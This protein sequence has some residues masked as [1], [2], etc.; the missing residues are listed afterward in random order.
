M[1]NYFFLLF[2][3]I[4]SCCCDNEFGTTIERIQKH[5]DIDPLGALIE[6]D[7][8]EKVADFSSEYERK[9]VQ[10]LRV[11]LNDKAYYTATSDVEIKKLLR[12]FRTHGSSKE[13]QEAFYYAGSVYRD[14]MDIPRSLEYFLHS[15]EIAKNG[16][17]DT[18]MLRNSYSQ[19]HNLY[20]RVQ[21]YGNALLAAEKECD[22]SSRLGIL[23]DVSRMHLVNA[24]FRRNNEDI[25]CK[26]MEEILQEEITAEENR[27]FDVL[28]DLLYSYS[29]IGDKEKAG[30]C[31]HL[32][33]S[34]EPLSPANYLALARYYSFVGES[35]SCVQC[36]ENV[37]SSN[38]LEAKY[39][40]SNQ[41]F[42][43]FMGKGDSEQALR[44]ATI[45]NDISAELNLSKRQELA[46][47]VN[48]QYK[49]YRDK[50]E[51][52]K[53]RKEGRFL[54]SL[55]WATGILCLIITIISIA[56]YYYQKYRRIKRL[57]GIAN[58][59][60]ITN[61]LKREK[62]QELFNEEKLVEAITKKFV[63]TKKEK[64]CIEQE[65]AATNVHITELTESLENAI[66]ECKTK[67]IALINKEEEL[68]NNEQS[69]HNRINEIT[70]I[71]LQLQHTEQE[72][73]KKTI[74][75]EEKLKQNE[76]LFR[77]LHQSDLHDNA[78]T[79]IDSIK[80]A[81]NGEEHLSDETWK[82]FITA[83]DNLYPLYHN[84]VIK[85]LGVMKKNQL[86]VCYL[87]KAG[88]SNTQIQNLVTDVSRATVWRWIKKYQTLLSEAINSI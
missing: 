75:L 49:Y 11:R 74:L 62:E 83:V 3:L 59:L 23:D 78:N 15:T 67:E 37:L 25:A 20:V 82:Q 44:Y 48:N 68:K 52:E 54:A 27:D 35:D 42:Q 70:I 22:I 81:A 36:Y 2:S 7:S 9:K 14:L 84:D 56:L 38:D 71:D 10:L 47:T 60:K 40:A 86:R 79:V 34:H 33:S 16:N 72:L 73:R 17:I 80:K 8:L 13:K 51:E 77:M 58:S 6:L 30:I 76:S 53:I 87:L 31:F 63:E 64:E 19:L 88:L 32:L 29:Y 24:H 39:D 18:L 61:E 43:Y 50:Q 28:F 85:T 21:D 55:A 12:Y 45:F 46:A 57:L 65:L 5:G 1:R 4:L 66:A 69:L 26:L 41:L